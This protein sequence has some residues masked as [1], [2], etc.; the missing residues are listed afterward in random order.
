MSAHPNELAALPVTVVKG[1]GGKLAQTLA[2][3]GIHTLQ[4]LL[5][6]LPHRYVDRTRI[7]P[8][9]KLRLNLAAVVQG[10]VVSANIQFGRRRSLACTIE[11]DTGS[12]MM[13]F[14]HF[15]AAQKDKLEPGTLVRCYGEPRMGTTGLEFYH[16][17]YDIV[18]DPSAKPVEEALTP[19]YGL[20]EGITQPRIRKLAEQALLELKHHNPAEYLPPEVGQMFGVDSLADALRYLHAPPPDAPV[21]QLIAGLHPYQQR[22]AFEELLA[23]YLA[24]QEARARAQAEASPVLRVAEQQRQAFLAQLP[25]T[26]TFAQTRVLGDINRDLQEGKPMLRMVQGDVGSGKTLV[27]ALAALDVISAGYQVA[28]VAPTEILAEQH[29][30]AFSNWLEPLGFNVAWLVGK[31][32]A[33]K[34]RDTVSA[35]AAGEVDVV[36]GTHA[37]FQ[38]DVLFASMGLAIVD[39]QHRF[40]VNQ[41]LTLRQKSIDGTIPHQLVMTATPIPR[42]LAMTAYAELDYSVIDELP[43]GRTP[44]NTVLISQKR[45]PQVIERILAA[46]KENKQVYWVCTLVEDSETLAAANAEE[47]AELLKNALKDINI[48][49]VHGRLKAAEKEAVM[50]AFKAGELQLLVATTVIEVG[51]DVPNASL[52]IIENPE[53]LGLAQLHQ[54]RGRVGRGSIASHCVMLYGDKLSMQAKERLGV[55]RETNDGFEIAEKDLA[56]RGPGELLGTR[57]TGEMEYR[58][59][60]LQRDA[61]MLDDIHKIG[62]A[63]CAHHPQTVEKILNRW[64]GA[65]REYMQA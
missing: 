25:F 20:T 30:I 23:H 61:G 40:G 3:L 51:V 37:L 38:D 9:G 34:R 17:E 45:R 5:F 57:Q 36:V 28:L 6:H 10:R 43:P 62:D 44:V 4:D 39:E 56:L 33:S 55:M 24:R 16:P 49:L 58:L 8:I 26:P 1:V 22:L 54:L 63:L 47:T 52:M 15:S 27:A 42:T 18:D 60:D 21:E 46:C 14:Y 2:K 65:R 48:G 59:A 32:T 12:L 19:V 35:I 7:T 13:R 41:R 29:Y 53:R 11:D 64:F 31:L 50:K